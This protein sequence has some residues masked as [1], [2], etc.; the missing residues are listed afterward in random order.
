MPH[1][2]VFFTF[3]PEAVK[4]LIDKPSDR[5]AM[6]SALCA[7][8]GASMESYYLMMGSAYDGFTVVDA[9]DSATV[10]AISLA[11]TGT[12]AFAHLETHELLESGDLGGILAQASGLAYQPPGA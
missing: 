5:A 2:A 10:A 12:G 11:V 1:Y 9:P 4:A 7:D 6:V 8:A 3:R